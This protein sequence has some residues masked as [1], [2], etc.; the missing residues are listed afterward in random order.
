MGLIAHI[1]EIPSCTELNPVIT[2][3]YKDE[4]KWDFNDSLVNISEGPQRGSEENNIL[5]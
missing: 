2:E 4:L 1:W 3:I 5:S